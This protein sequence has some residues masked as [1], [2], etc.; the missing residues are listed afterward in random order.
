MFSVCSF[1]TFSF[2]RLIFPLFF[3]AL[4]SINCRPLCF[5][6]KLPLFSSL[7]SGCFPL[8]PQGSCDYISVIYFYKCQ[9]AILPSI[10][11]RT[12]ERKGGEMGKWQQKS[13]VVKRNEMAAKKRR[14]ESIHSILSFMLIVRY[15]RRTN[16]RNSKL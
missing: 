15:F 5:S 16:F 1:V 7:T 3:T 14:Y 8:L 4:V 10:Q 6:L 13:G 9:T 11:R 2:S 12:D